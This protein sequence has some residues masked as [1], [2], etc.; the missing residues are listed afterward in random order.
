MWLA[1]G[2]GT[3]IGTCLWYATRRDSSRDD[4]YRLRKHITSLSPVAE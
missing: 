3:D 1:Y 4:I 2:T